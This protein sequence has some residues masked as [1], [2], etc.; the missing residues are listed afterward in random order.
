MAADLLKTNF[1]TC[2]IKKFSLYTVI[3]LG[4]SIFKKHLCEA[5]CVQKGCSYKHSA[6]V[7]QK[8]SYLPQVH[9]AQSKIKITAN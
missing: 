5:N 9:R 2:V 7:S 6:N 8:N 4:A 1:F 3:S